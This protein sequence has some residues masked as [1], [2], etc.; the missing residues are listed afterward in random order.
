MLAPQPQPEMLFTPV[1][2]SVP[3]DP[4]PHGRAAPRAGVVHGDPG[5][6]V[7]VEQPRIVVARDGVVAAHPLELVEGPVVADVV[8]VDG[9]EAG[10]AE[11]G[12]IIGVVKWV[13]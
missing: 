1:K 6:G 3:T 8:V 9:I 11:A 2:V 7:G 10:R 5:G 13:P 4:S 12:R